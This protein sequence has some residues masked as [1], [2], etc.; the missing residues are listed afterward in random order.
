MLTEKQF[1]LCFFPNYAFLR[2]CVVCAFLFIGRKGK[3]MKILHIKSTIEK[4]KSMKPLNIFLF[5]NH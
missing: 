1:I 2:M 4:G 5:S 3:R